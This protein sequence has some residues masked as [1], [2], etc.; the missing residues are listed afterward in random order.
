M[1]YYKTIM[2]FP[3]EDFQKSCPVDATYTYS[4]RQLLSARTT[5]TSIVHNMSLVLPGDAVPLPASSSAG[6]TLGPGLRPIALRSL[7]PLGDDV[8]A[9]DEAGPS[10]IVSSRMG[11]LGSGSGKAKGTG[12]EKSDRVWVEGTSRRVSVAPAFA[13]SEQR[14]TRRGVKRRATGRRK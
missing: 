6:I 14:T 3:L 2:P 8:A 4:S 7:D 12:K 13:Q 10:D 5:T 9:Q 1:R 11:L